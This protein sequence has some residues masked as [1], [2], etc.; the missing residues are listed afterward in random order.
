MFRV[1]KQR[2]GN[3]TPNGQTHISSMANSWPSDM[4]KVWSPKPMGP[5]G[6][7][8]CVA[9]FNQWFFWFTDT[10]FDH[11]W[12]FREDFTD[13]HGQIFSVTFIV[14][15]DMP[16]TLRK[17]IDVPMKYRGF[18]IFFSLEPIH[19]HKSSTMSWSKHATYQMPTK[20][21]PGWFRTQL[22]NLGD[23]ITYC[24]IPLVCKSTKCLITCIYRYTY[25]YI[26][27]YLHIIY[28]YTCLYI[29]NLH[30]KYIYIHTYIYIILHI[31]YIYIY[32]ML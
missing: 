30:I 4:E 18:L 9:S 6:A 19:W 1:A 25:L 21:R 3:L 27:I 22:P 29:Y 24:W 16:H 7:E 20:I 5:W 26:Y 17:I 15:T 14:H 23:H 2:F 11:F 10:F 31:K 32:I 12:P 13:L 28:I 8:T